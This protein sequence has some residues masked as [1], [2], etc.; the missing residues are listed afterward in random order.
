M[1]LPVLERGP[2]AVSEHERDALARLEHLL[3]TGGGGTPKVVGPGGEQ[4]DLPEAVVHL[5]RQVVHAMAQDQAVTVIPVHKQLT[6]Q[7]AADVLNVSRPYLVHLLNA[8]E[9]PYVKTGSHRR[10]RFDDLMAYKQRRDAERQVGLDRLSQLG[11]DMGL[12]SK[13]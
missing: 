3:E 13:S 9:I 11:Q 6:T 10:I 12:Y 4:I 7:Q 2:M 8:G 1:A 5:L